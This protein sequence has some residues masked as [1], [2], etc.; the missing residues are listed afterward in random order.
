MTGVPDAPDGEWIATDDD[1]ER[2]RYLA[3]VLR[4]VRRGLDDG[5]DI[6]GYFV[7]SLLDNFEW[8][9]GFGPKFGLQRLIGGTSLP[10]QAERIV[11]RGCRRGKT[12]RRRR[13]AEEEYATELPR[14]RTPRGASLD[15]DGTPMA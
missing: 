3:E 9:H 8:S 5:V 10:C 12:A 15:V 6:R 1:A 4:G 11:V 2:I 13:Q 7:W 14:H